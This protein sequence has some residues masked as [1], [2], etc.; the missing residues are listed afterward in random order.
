MDP[1]AEHRLRNKMN[2]VGFIAD[3]QCG[4]RYWNFDR[5]E[6]V[7]D[8]WRRVVEQDSRVADKGEGVAG[9]EQQIGRWVGMEV[10]CNAL[11]DM[12]RQG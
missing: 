7:H 2:S 3:I 8:G 1:N 6:Q 5:R 11:V 10:A 4:K 12:E 9:T